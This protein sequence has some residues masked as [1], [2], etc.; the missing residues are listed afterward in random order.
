MKNYTGNHEGN[1]KGSGLKLLYS[2]PNG[3]LYNLL[4]N[5]PYSLPCSF[6]YGFLHSMFNKV[7]LLIGVGGRGQEILRNGF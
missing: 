6:L 4:H 7:L 2:F 5:C 3:L 1:Y